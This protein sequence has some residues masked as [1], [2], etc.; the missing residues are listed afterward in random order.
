M[1]R[2]RRGLGGRPGRVAYSVQVLDIPAVPRS[3]VTEYQMMART[4]ECG[5]VTHRRCRA[6][7]VTGGPVCYGRK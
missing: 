4:C 6:P 3:T 2:V 7:G 5:Q 1:R